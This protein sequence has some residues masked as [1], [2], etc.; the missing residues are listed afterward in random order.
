MGVDG[1]RNFNVHWAEVG[2]SADPCSEI[3]HGTAA[4]S[5]AETR[6]VRDAAAR[7]RHKLRTYLAIHSYGNFILY[8]YGH[9]KTLTS[10]WRALVC[11]YLH[12]EA[13]Q[14][15]YTLLPQVTLI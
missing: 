2:S 15:Y 5:E 11:T 1:N 8:P 13:S 4:F 14:T 10:D 3:Y 6:A 12:E 9:T 7:Y